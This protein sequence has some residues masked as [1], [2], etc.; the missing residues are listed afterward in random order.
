MQKHNLDSTPVQQSCKDQCGHKVLKYC[1]RVFQNRHSIEKDLQ[2]EHFE[3][4]LFVHAQPRKENQH[5]QQVTITKAYINTRKAMEMS[6][7]TQLPA[8]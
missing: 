4:R 6:I 8:E 7:T 3:T 1:E 5:P 2:Q